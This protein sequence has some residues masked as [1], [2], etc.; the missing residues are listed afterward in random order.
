MPLDVPAPPSPGGAALCAPGRAPVR[1]LA[2]PVGLVTPGVIS[3]RAKAA[4]SSM[5]NDGPGLGPGRYV[6]VRY[7]AHP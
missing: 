5:S 6:A 4:A 7:R 1:T 2:V 3:R